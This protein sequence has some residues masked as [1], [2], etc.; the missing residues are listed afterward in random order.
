M[1]TGL[2]MTG[3]D[4]QLIIK[5]LRDYDSGFPKYDALANNLSIHLSELVPQGEEQLFKV[6]RY[7]KI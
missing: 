6:E 7:D 2:I 5:A 4:L 3:E 1:K